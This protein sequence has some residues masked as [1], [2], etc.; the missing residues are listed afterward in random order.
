MLN[1]CADPPERCSIKTRLSHWKGK[2]VKAGKFI[3][4]N[5]LN[6]CPDLFPISQNSLNTMAISVATIATQQTRESVEP[7]RK[8]VFAWYLICWPYYS[9]NVL[10]L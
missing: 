5:S 8:Y 7:A 2:M 10:L 1:N 9:N 6:R 3:E 4:Q